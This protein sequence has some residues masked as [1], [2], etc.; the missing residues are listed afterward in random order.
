MREKLAETVTEPDEQRVRLVKDIRE[1]AEKVLEREKLRD[2][3]AMEKMERTRERERERK[4][5]ET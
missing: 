1:E 4:S 2:L 5:E 3:Q